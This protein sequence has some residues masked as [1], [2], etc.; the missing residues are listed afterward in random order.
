MYL[1][2]RKNRMTGVTFVEGFRAAKKLDVGGGST[3]GRVARRLP[4]IIAYFRACVIVIFSFMIFGR[5][6]L[7]MIILFGYDLLLQL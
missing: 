5:V 7:L 4:L 1:E 6:R 2:A 3:F